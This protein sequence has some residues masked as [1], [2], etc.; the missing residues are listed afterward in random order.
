MKLMYNHNVL[1]N[2]WMILAIHD[3]DILHWEGVAVLVLKVYE[4]VCACVLCL[5]KNIFI[6]QAEFVLMYMVLC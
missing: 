6:S 1:L 4:T 3:I 5:Y 2:E